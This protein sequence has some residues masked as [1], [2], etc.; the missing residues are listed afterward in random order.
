MHVSESVE[1]LSNQIHSR[2]SLSPLQAL[3]HRSQP[4]GLA[5]CHDQRSGARHLPRTPGLRRSPSG[6]VPGARLWGAVARPC[7]ELLCP[8]YLPVP[9]PEGHVAGGGT[10]AVR[11]NVSAPVPGAQSHSPAQQGSPQRLL[12]E[13]RLSQQ[14]QLHLP[15]CTQGAHE[16]VPGP[17][18]PGLHHVLLALCRLD[19]KAV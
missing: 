4:S 2:F 6:L 12:Q 19:A 18:P 11:S 15:L 13:H 14:H 8:T 16:Q 17:H 1:I 9:E 10:S 5:H 7:V 3:Y